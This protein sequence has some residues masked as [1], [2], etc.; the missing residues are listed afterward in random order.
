MKLGTDYCMRQIKIPNETYL[1]I[2]HYC[3]NNRI[4]LIYFYE[5]MLD[6]FLNE[7]RQQ[8]TLVYQASTKH[9]RTLSLW[10]RRRQIDLINKMATN[11]KVSDARVIYT[12][13]MLY[14]ENLPELTA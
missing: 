8:N 14:L 13:M 9:R 10:I 1:V 7:H 3:K 5:T 4:S 6:W 2:K 12:A 11:A